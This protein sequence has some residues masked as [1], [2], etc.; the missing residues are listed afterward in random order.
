MYNT[1]A[2]FIET[3]SPKEGAKCLSMEYEKTKYLLS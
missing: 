3:G 1:D 2:L